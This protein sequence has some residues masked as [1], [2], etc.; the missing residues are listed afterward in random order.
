MGN[1]DNIHISICLLQHKIDLWIRKEHEGIYREA[2]KRINERAANFAKKNYT[3]IQDL[4][5][6]LLLELTVNYIAKEKRLNAYEEKLLPKVEQLNG[7]VDRLDQAIGE[8][9]APATDST[10]TQNAD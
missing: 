1:S 7:L 3:D 5:T 6:K 9:E 8:A 2:E 4:L 10:E